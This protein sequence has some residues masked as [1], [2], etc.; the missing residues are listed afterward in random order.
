MKKI[1]SRVLCILTCVLFIA[2][3]TASSIQR[4]NLS[5][6][7]FDGAIFDGVETVLRD[8]ISDSDA[9]R[10][11]HQGATG[12]VSVQ[13]VRSSAEDRAKDF[14][15]NKGLQYELL[16]ERVSTGAHVAGNFP[17][18]ELVFS[19]ISK[20]SDYVS[21]KEQVIKS[22]KYQELREL[23]ALLDEGIITQEEYD[24]EKSK[25]LKD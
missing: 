13:S 23:K 15:S 21:H 16:R 3:S 7:G 12:F 4:A 11:F 18:A 19:C 2:C 10:I 1:V 5:K 25:I 14:C 20:S 9:Y 24:Q 6:S 22:I 8:D 17:R